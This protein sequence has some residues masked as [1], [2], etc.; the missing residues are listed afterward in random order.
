MEG[1]RLRATV[2]LYRDAAISTT[3]NDGGKEVHVEAGQRLMVDLV[4]DLTLRP[5]GTCS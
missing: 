5:V 1:S 4:S 3:I 2:G